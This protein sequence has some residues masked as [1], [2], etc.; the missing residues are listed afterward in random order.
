M[1]RKREKEPSFPSLLV[2]ATE[3]AEMADKDLRELVRRSIKPPYVREAIPGISRSVVGDIVH[4]IRERAI[5]IARYSAQ[6]PFS[7]TSQVRDMLARIER[8][9]KLEEV[10]VYPKR[11]M[12][13]HGEPPM[14]IAA[15]TRKGNDTITND[16]SPLESWRVLWKQKMQVGSRVRR[17]RGTNPPVEIV[18]RININGMLFFT[19]NS[20]RTR[21]SGPHEFVKIK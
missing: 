10:Y 13:F 7:V 12:E 3:L 4:E 6:S 20:S 9:V 5:R 19:S 18:R 14:P 1:S 15:F 11:L 2:P 21:G 16:R 8:E 17:I